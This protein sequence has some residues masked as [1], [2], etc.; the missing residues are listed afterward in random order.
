MRMT[1]DAIQAS[2]IEIVSSALDVA[3]ANVRLHSSLIDDLGAESIDFID[4][5]FRLESAF[6]IK[7]P[8][9]AIWRGAL[10]ADDPDEMARGIDQLRAAMP[11]FGWDRLP[12]RLTRADLPRLITVR[13]IVEYL[14]R[15]LAAE[16][17]E[18]GV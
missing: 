14:D 13:T 2:V 1:R 9:D 12:P 17:G 8:E 10:N 6:A 5:L 18:G 4:I 11:E 3:P 16:S 7:I 15:R